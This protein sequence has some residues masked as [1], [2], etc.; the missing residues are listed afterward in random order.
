[1]L[2]AKTLRHGRGTG[3]AGKQES[4]EG[5]VLVVARSIKPKVVS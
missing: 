2:A 4:T 5:K 1:M 3:T